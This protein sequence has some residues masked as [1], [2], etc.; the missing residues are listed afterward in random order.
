MRHDR[1][2]V[3]WSSFLAEI[4]ASLDDQVALHCLGGFAVAMVYGLPRPTIDIDV[5]AVTPGV[6]TERL[7]SLAGRGSALHKSHGV[8]LQY[9]G[10]VH[11]PENYEQRLTA[12]FPNAF[13]RLTLLGLE[14]MTS[15]S[16]SW[17]GTRGGTGR[18]SGFSREPCRSTPRS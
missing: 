4:D 17:S 12:I 3:P 15:R 16:Q 10:V 2:P 9:V 1:P 6:Q 11:I 8:Y 14:A 13:R 5:L 18:T 7:L